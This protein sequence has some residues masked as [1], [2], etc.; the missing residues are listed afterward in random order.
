MTVTCERQPD[1]YTFMRGA[2]LLA[3]LT[4]RQILDPHRPRAAPL[5]LSPEEFTAL[6]AGVVVWEPLP[7]DQWAVRWVAGQMALSDVLDV[8]AATPAEA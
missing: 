5:Q 2:A 4:T 1:G 6:K 7:K 3:R 8:I